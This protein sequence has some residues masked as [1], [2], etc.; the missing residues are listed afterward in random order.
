MRRDLHGLQLATIFLF[1]PHGGAIKHSDG[2]IG[3]PLEAS[4]LVQSEL[5][6]DLAPKIS[7]LVLLELDRVLGQVRGNSIAEVRRLIGLGR[8]TATALVVTSL[9]DNRWP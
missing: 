9:R 2:P 3:L 8:T 6:H 7:Q 4:L 5:M 1:V